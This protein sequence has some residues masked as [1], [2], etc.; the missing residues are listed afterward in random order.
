MESSRQTDDLCCQN[1]TNSSSISRISFTINNQ[2]QANWLPSLNPLPTI[3][4]DSSNSTSITNPN[5]FQPFN[6]SPPFIRKL[7]NSSENSFLP[8]DSLQYVHFWEHHRCF[9][10]WIMDQF[11]I[12]TSSFFSIKIEI[13]CNWAPN[14][15]RVFILVIKFRVYLTKKSRDREVSMTKIR[16]LNPLHFKS[17]TFLYSCLISRKL[18]KQI[19]SDFST[20]KLSRRR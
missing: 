7:K 20:Q 4:P 1:S 12:K 2:N 13:N 5:S 17:F 11:I 8:F 16:R 18:G 3:F 19:V 10:I 15:S 14:E 9:S 6:C